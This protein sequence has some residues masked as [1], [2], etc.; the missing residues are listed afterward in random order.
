VVLIGL[1][2]LIP[3]LTPNLIPSHLRITP[4]GVI[5]L[6]KPIKPIKV[7]ITYKTNKE[8]ERIGKEQKMVNGFPEL[9]YEDRK[10]DRLNLGPNGMSIDLLRAVYRNPSIPLP[11]RMRA[12]IACLPHETPRL[13]VQALVNEQSF[14]ELLERRLKHQAQIEATN[15]KPQQ[16]EHQMIETSRP[17]PRSNDRRLRRM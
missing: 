11:V 15:G 9:V 6:I 14:A 10:E 1:I 8:V 17:L 16:I 4:Y 2:G 13:M 12:A 5:K 3:L 7:E